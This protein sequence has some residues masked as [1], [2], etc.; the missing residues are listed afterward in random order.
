MRFIDQRSVSSHT[1][2]I[3]NHQFRIDVQYSVERPHIQLVPG[4]PL[5]PPEQIRGCF[6]KA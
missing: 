6:L 2:D 3:R 5:A 1:L 4:G